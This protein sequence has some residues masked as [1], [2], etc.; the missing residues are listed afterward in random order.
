MTIQSISTQDSEQEGHAIVVAEV[1]SL[2]RNDRALEE[3]MDRL[4]IEPG[5]T[6][7][8]WERVR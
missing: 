1:F 8:R 5:V 6:A 2:E 3:I 4:N 7:V